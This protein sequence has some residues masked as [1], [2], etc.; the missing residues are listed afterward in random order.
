MT[1]IVIHAAVAQNSVIGRD[2]GLPWKLSTD[3]KRFKAATM[4]RPVVMG[5]KTFESVGK[6]LPGRLNVVVTRD[7]S[8]RPEGVEVAHSLEDAITLARIRLRCT[9]TRKP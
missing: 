8:F 5:R 2:S 9:S 7:R 4:G 6:A 1:S 3:L